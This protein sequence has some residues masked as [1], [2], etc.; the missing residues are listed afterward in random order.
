MGVMMWLMMRGGQGNQAQSMND[1]PPMGQRTMAPASLRPDVDGR[2][3]CAPV[4]E[5]ARE[6]H[7]AALRE[8]LARLQIEQKAL[9]GQ[10]AELAGEST[11][12]PMGEDPRAR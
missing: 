8:R 4:I 3:D 6:E 5:Q 2:A 12:A 10:M 9:A 11:T 1:A 7:V